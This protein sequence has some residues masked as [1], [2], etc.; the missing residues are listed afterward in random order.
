M[1]KIENDT[2]LVHVCAQGTRF[3]C[4]RAD[5][6][7]GVHFQVSSYSGVEDVMQDMF[8]FGA[9]HATMI[10]PQLNSFSGYDCVSFT[11]VS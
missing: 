5:L 4:E 1:Q 8:E 11:K 7:N 6:E 10:H 9:W 2:R 3:E